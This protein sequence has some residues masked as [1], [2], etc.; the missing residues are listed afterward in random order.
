M[1]YNSNEQK[2]DTIYISSKT[3]E[4]Y[5]NKK[6]NKLLRSVAVLISNLISPDITRIFSYTINP[7]ST[8]ILMKY[9]GGVIATSDEGY[10]NGFFEWLKTNDIKLGPST[11]RRAF[12]EYFEYTKNTKAMNEYEY[13][14]R[15]QL[16]VLVYITEENIQKAQH[17]FDTT[18][19]ELICN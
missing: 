8:Y 1:L 18:L 13:N 4:L 3:D 10:N 7:V 11:Y 17:M 2:Q 9:L 16:V 19:K 6:Y 5:E 12:E 14:D 15:Y